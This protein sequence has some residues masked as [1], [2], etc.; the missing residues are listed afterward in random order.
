MKFRRLN[1]WNMKKRHITIK[2]TPKNGNIIMPQPHIGGRPFHHIL[3]H[4]FFNS[5]PNQSAPQLPQEQVSPRAFS[6][7]SRPSRNERAAMTMAPA[8][9]MPPIPVSSYPALANSRTHDSHRQ[10]RLQFAS[11]RMASERSWRPT[12]IL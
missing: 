7:A 5:M 9:S 6:K 3:F 10:T 12:F 8:A 2:R 1:I 4:L 11:A